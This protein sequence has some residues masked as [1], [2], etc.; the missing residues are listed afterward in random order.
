MWN[1]VRIQKEQQM[2][3]EWTKVKIETRAFI[4]FSFFGESTSTIWKNKKQKH[5]ETNE[6]QE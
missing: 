3:G 2:K 1:E 5:I 4:H 6:Y